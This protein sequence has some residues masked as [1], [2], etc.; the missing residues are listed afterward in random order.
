MRLRRVAGADPLAVRL[1]LTAKPQ[2]RILGRCN[3]MVRMAV[4]EQLVLA[5]Q[6]PSSVMVAASA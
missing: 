1:I 4:E 3:G 5:L 6:D 2:L